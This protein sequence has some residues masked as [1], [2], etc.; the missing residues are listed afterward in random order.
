MTMKEKYDSSEIIDDK[1]EFREKRTLEIV[2]K[3]WPRLRMLYQY[4]FRILLINII[5]AIIVTLYLVFFTTP[6]YLS[7][8]FLMPD[9]GSKTS[10]LS[11]YSN[12]MSLAGI[13]LG[14]AKSSSIYNNL[15]HSEAVLENVIN[16]YFLT[17]ISSDSV[18]LIKYFDVEPE[19]SESPELEARLMFLT[20]YT[21]FIENILITEIDPSSDILKLTINMPES[22]LSADVANKIVESLDDYVRNKRKSLASEQRFYLEKRTQEVFDSLT[23]TEEQL[24]L[25]R[26]Q[27]RVIKSPQLMLEQGRLVRSL[28]ILQATYIELKK[29]LE[30]I[31]LDE[32]K[33]TPVINLREQAREPVIKAGPRR[34]L[35]LVIIMFFVFS[36]TCFYYSFK[37]S[38]LK[39]ISIIKNG[40]N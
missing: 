17:E 14:E 16:S 2:T 29:Q 28:E 38:I 27:N 33:D 21:K 6:V 32:I 26:E 3:L 37:P 11:Q 12:L 31:K 34:F 7:S 19:E 24:K 35:I 9:Y 25:F 1:N 8:V 10:S 5:A 18:N 23:I 39:Y 20:V 13:K 36:I 4:R 22:K 30:L 40:I 15:I